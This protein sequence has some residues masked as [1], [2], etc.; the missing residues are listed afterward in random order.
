M[1][2]FFADLAIHLSESQKSFFFFHFRI[3]K[4]FFALKNRLHRRAS[5]RLS[6]V[7]AHVK[8]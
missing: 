2:F 6:R 4:I 3:V 5:L 8:I 7:K 1:I